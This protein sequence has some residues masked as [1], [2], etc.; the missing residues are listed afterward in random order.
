LDIVKQIIFSLGTYTEAELI[1]IMKTGGIFKMFKSDQKT[2][3]EIK[4]SPDEV[5]L[6][7]NQKT[8]I[9]VIDSTE[10][11]FGSKT[12][13]FFKFKKKEEFDE[14]LCF[15]IMY[16]IRGVNK[17]TADGLSVDIM[18]GTQAEFQMWTE[19]LKILCDTK[20]DPEL[21][22]VKNSWRALGKDELNLREV[23]NML[24]QINYRVR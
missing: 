9:P 5:S 22:F 18:A 2:S 11:R 17:V 19:G 8:I 14:N 7:I 20:L 3:V 24:Q 6:Q 10:V 15:S 12:M 21:A 1:S 13:S 16:G 4:L 23:I